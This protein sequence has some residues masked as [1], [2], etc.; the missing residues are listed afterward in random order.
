MLPALVVSFT[1]AELTGSALQAGLG[2][3]ENEQL[4][5][6][7]VLGVAAVLLLTLMLVAPQIVGVV[8][9]LKARRA[10][11]RHI[12]TAGLI[13]NAVVAAFVV[14]SAGVNLLLL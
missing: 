2:L 8:L 3:D 7:G 12:G 10:G 14:L 5:N 13:L 11:V 6:A 4:T 1:A 9:G